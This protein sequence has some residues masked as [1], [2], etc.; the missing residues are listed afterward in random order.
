LWST[1][2]IEGDRDPSNPASGFINGWCSARG[3]FG[4]LALPRLIEFHNVTLDGPSGRRVE[5]ISTP[6]L[7]ELATL[8]S[9]TDVSLHRPSLPIARNTTETLALRGRSLE[10]NATF[11]SLLHGGGPFDVGLAVLT[12][13]D[14]T[15]TTRVGI[16]SGEHL[17][18]VWLWD[19]V[20][21]D[22]LVRNVTGGSEECKVLCAHHPSCEAWSYSN[23]KRCELK[24]VAD[25]CLQQASAHANCFLPY[26]QSDGS[27]DL[28]VSGYRNTDPKKMVRYASLYIERELS[29]S[30]RNL[31]YGTHNFA[32]MLRILPD[33]ED[34]IQLHVFVDRSIVEAFA[35]NGRAAVTARVYPSVTSVYVGLFSK[36]S[37]LGAAARVDG[38]SMNSA[39]ANATAFLT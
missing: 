28:P 6:P 35:M 5:F 27:G 19:E 29:S 15:E 30:S 18:G 36:A 8:R 12:S 3:W 22:V 10:I 13:A 24:R 38:W 21:A 37:P 1:T 33:D 39:L 25:A 11:T 2:L 9:T 14:G 16:R 4:A 20:N 34:I 31:T 23:G 7:P 17:D 26:P 32:Q